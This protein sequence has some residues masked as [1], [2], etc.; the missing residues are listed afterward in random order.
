MKYKKLAALIYLLSCF[1]FQRTIHKVYNDPD[2]DFK[3]AKELYQQQQFSWLIRS[4]K[5]Y[6]LTMQGKA[7]FLSACKLRRSIMQ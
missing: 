2:A 7:V 4:L 6:I 1:V 3:Q 5:S